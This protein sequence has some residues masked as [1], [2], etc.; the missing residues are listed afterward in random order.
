MTKHKKMNFFEKYKPGVSKRT[1]LFVAGVIWSLAGGI[2][3]TRALSVLIVSSEHLLIE[4]IIASILGICFYIFL[5]TKISRK[6]IKRIELIKI[7]FPCFF[8]FFNVKS[9][10]LMAIM[11]TG[12]I[13]LRKTEVIK[14]EYLNTF[15]FTMGIPLLLSAGR[16]FI[17]GY[18]NSLKI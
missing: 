11:I 16:F 13:I 9:Y 15:F 12:G 18:R 8:S 1:L 6:H 10:I 14:M 4:L 5:F 7:D 3:I 2:L 17:S